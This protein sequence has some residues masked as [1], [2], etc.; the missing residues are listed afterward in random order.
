MIDPLFV[1]VYQGDVGGKPNWAALFADGRVSGAI[2]KATEGI[3]YGPTWFD[4]QWKALTPN[5]D[6]PRPDFIRGAYHF[7][8]F[9]LDGKAQ[10]DFYL[11]VINRAGGFLPG[12]I[13]PIVD[14][15]MGGETHPNHNAS[16]QQ[17]IDA[18]S[19]FAARLNELGYS[20]V[21][22]Y[23]NGAMRD[24]N[25]T[26]RMGC[27]WLWIPRYTATLP[28]VIYQRA[29]WSLDQVAL[30]QYCGDGTGFL[31]GYPTRIEGFGAVDISVAIVKDLSVFRQASTTSDS[32]GSIDTSTALA[33]NADNPPSSSP[34][35]NFD[36]PPTSE[37]TESA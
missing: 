36:T 3:A 37:T 12:D 20:S 25:I 21:M 34:W 13:I 17:V 23:G 30:W 27:D 14:V 11:K 15:E 6:G 16:A 26:T 35:D 4:T 28:A 31:A 1:D 2:I 5:P 10:A 9:D 18:T 22:L 7:L 24:L 29:G 32:S 19:A 8:R 33:S